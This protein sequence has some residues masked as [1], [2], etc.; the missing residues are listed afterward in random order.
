MVIWEY[1]ATV[2]SKLCVTFLTVCLPFYL[3]LK[4]ETNDQIPVTKQL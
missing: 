1:H 4:Y 3:F 2:S